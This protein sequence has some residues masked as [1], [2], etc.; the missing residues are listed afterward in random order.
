MVAH[1]LR[2]GPRKPIPRGANGGRAI[3]TPR[4]TTPIANQGGAVRRQY[5][6][7]NVLGIGAGPSQPDAAR[8]GR[9]RTPARGPLRR[10]P[11]TRI[12]AAHSPTLELAP[13]RR[14]C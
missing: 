12:V 9:P 1:L 6:D 8:V 7:L 2:G 14:G 11:A 3:R 13:F 4:I 10:S 5:R